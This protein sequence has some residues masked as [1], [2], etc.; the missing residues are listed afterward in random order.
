MTLIDAMFIGLYVGCCIGMCNMMTEHSSRL[1][2][3]QFAARALSCAVLGAFAA[4]QVWQVLN[5]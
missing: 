1:T 4:F 2:F 5:K 3:K